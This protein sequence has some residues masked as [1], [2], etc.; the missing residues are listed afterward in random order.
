[1]ARQ[2]HSPEQHSVVS[3]ESLWRKLLVALRPVTLDIYAMG[4]GK[5]R[6][7]GTEFLEI[8]L[9]PGRNGQFKGRVLSLVQEADR[10]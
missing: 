7:K 10:A 2:P 1:M 3:Q 9:F 6:N 4:W 8:C 5:Q